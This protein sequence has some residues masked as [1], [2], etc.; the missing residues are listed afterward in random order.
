[1]AERDGGSTVVYPQTELYRPVRVS[2]SMLT[3]L[4]L[5][6]QSALMIGIYSRYLHIQS[7]YAH[8]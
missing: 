8:I 3:A 4:L 5:G 7:S 1:M 6:T 2:V